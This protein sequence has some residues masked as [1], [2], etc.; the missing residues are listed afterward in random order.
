MTAVSAWSHHSD[1]G[2]DM[3]VE[4]DLHERG[5]LVDACDGDAREF[6]HPSV[7]V[8]V[9]ARSSFACRALVRLDRDAVQNSDASTRTHRMRILSALA[10]REEKDPVRVG[11]EVRGESRLTVHLGVRVGLQSDIADDVS[12]NRMWVESKCGAFGHADGGSAR[13]R[14]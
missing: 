8:R 6:E 11:M 14:L 3:V 1:A 10:I 9:T 7:D 4:P 13:I 2:M 12:S 5:V